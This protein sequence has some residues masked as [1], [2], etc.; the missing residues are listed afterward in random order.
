MLIND[1]VSISTDVEDG[2]DLNY[3]QNR[4]KY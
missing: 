1:F 2:S 3:A 4:P